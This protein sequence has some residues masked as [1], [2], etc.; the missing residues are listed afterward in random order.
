METHNQ[1]VV[2]EP[3]WVQLKIKALQILFCEAFCFSQVCC[4][5]WEGKV[6]VNDNLSFL[7]KC[8]FLRKFTL[9]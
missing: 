1:G 4:Q 2:F 8:Y 6:G 7:T 3:S 5:D 9:N